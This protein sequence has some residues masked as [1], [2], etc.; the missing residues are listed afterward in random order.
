MYLKQEKGGIWKWISLFFAVMI[1]FTILSRAIY[2]YGTAVVRTEMPSSGTINH[3][4][5]ITGK[6]L[7]NQELAVTTIGGLRIGSICV[8]EGQHVKQGDVLFIL[9][10]DYLDEAI[11]KQEQDMKKQQLSVWDAWAQNSNAQ[12]QRENQQAQAEEN[13]DNAVAQAQT[14][15]D[16]AKR[17]LDRAKTALENFYNGVSNEKEEEDALLLACQEAKRD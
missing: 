16:R 9:D 11:L 6:V 1:L 2:Q 8:N 15:V 17:D 3:T 14:A 7:Q 5:Q 12:K 13:Y 4:V 10:L